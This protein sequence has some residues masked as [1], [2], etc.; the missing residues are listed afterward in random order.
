M[1][2]RIPRSPF[3]LLALAL[4]AVPCP[5][6][7][8]G[9]SIFEQGS[10][11]MGLAGAFTA[12]SDPSSIFHNAAGIAFLKGQ[13]VYVGGTLVHPLLDFTGANPFPGEGVR[14]KGDVGLIPVPAVYYTRAFSERLVFG[15]GVHTPFGLR[16]EWKNP[17][18]SS[19]RFISQVADLK[20][21]SL[22]PTVAYKLADRLAVGAGV[23]LRFSKVRLER[24]VP[25]V[26]PFTQKVKDAAEVALTS[27]W[28]T[29]VGFN[30]GLLARPSESLSLGLAYR[31]KVATDFTGSA[32]FTALPTGSAQLDAALSSVVPA[33]AL[34]V[35]TALEFPAIASLG[36]AY[37]WND[38]TVEADVDYFQ[39]SSFDR[40]D[41]TFPDRPDLDDTTLELYDNSFQFRL[42]VERP[43]SEAWT[44]RGGYFFD[45]SPA[46]AAAVS[47]LLPDSNRHG[48]ALGGT[49]QR[50][51]LRL[52]AASWFLLGVSRSTEGSNHD[53]YDGTYKNKAINFGLSVGYEF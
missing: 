13:Q 7:A 9:F 45:Q 53:R 11:G 38:W 28:G 6:S 23:D 31:H 27:D 39:W 50:G 34:D 12:Q 47:L 49:W 25:V 42:G 22:N 35:E 19:G 51:R 16:T 44:A 26:D 8:A 43:I 30:V 36:V 29:G 32:R 48:F 41:L 17:E 20:S 24:R 46:P 52:D 40:L 37:V 14:E 18:T 4:A 33:G 10:R 2:S 1:P 15:V 5:L 21:L 3:L